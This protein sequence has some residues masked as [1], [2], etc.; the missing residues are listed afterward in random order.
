MYALDD[1]TEIGAFLWIT[2]SKYGDLGLIRKLHK[3]TY[4]SGKKQRN[5]I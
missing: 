2:G 4:E 3:T 5:D 1:V